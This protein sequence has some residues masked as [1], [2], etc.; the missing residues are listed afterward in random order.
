MGKILDEAQ[1]A[2]DDRIKPL[3]D[4]IK[5][6]ENVIK[7]LR[8]LDKDGKGVPEDKKQDLADNEAK[9]NTLRK[10]KKALVADYAAGQPLIK[11]LIDIA[12]LGNGLLKG[13]PLSTFL[14]RSV[15]LL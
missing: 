15:D 2:L 13:E 6:T 1:A 14:R 12:L 9:V 5:S 3:D 8:D 7:A 10:D 11:Q 4:Q